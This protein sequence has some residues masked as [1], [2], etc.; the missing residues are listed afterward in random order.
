MPGHAVRCRRSVGAGGRLAAVLALFL[1]V[2]QTA[3]AKSEVL[4]CKVKH[5]STLGVNTPLNLTGHEVR[6][7]FDRARRR[8][9]VRD[10]MTERYFDGASPAAVRRNRP[11]EF[12]IEWQLPDFPVH[13]A[14]GGSVTTFYLRVKERSNRFK[15]EIIV[16]GRGT[17]LAS[18]KC[19]V[20]K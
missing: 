15:L 9:Q 8:A 18:G 11:G 5:L 6:V 7:D 19:A 17:F 2:P 20:S 4:I 14:E 13:R 3:M 12:E 10:A 1:L 16:S